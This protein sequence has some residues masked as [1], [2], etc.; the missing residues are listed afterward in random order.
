MI[1]RLEAQLGGAEPNPEE[2]VTDVLGDD[3][4]HADELED[5]WAESA[6]DDDDNEA[7]TAPTPSGQAAAIGREIEEL[8]GYRKLADSIRANAKGDALLI[9][10][11]I[12]FAKAHE[13]G[14]PRKALIFTESRRTQLYLLQLLEE[15]GYGG[16]IV[17]FNGTNADAASKAI[18]KQ[19]LKRHEGRDSISGSPTSDM[20]SALVEE[21]RDR[22]CIMIATESAAEGVNLQFC[23]LVVNYDL[24]WNP[25]RIEQRI[26]GCHRYG[27]KYE[28]VVV[29]FLN[30]ENQAD[31]R[32]FELLDEKFKLFDG[33][34]GASDEVLGTL[35]SGADFE[36]RIN[37]IYQSCRSL[38]E[39]NAAFDQLQKEFETKITAGLSDARQKLLENFDH[40]VH[41]NCTC[42]TNGQLTCGATANGSGP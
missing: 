41:R 37:A 35:A 4:D 26:G 42:A 16:Q 7:S 8:K 38:P 39:I 23:S 29:N 32:V 18:Y 31:Q 11:K 1:A 9:A 34:F 30:R 22:A 24:P 33:V 10:L 36:S 13:L 17:L 6:D 14:A 21:F 27:Q 19:W 40:E 2:H 15:N 5:E 3:L 25:Q 12:A 20:R 28:V